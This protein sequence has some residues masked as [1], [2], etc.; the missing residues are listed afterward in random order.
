MK[1][2]FVF[3]ASAV[4][5][6]GVI[7]YLRD[8][9]KGK[10][11]PNIVSWIT[12]TLLTGIA[13]IAELVGHEYHTAIFTAA[14]V[15]ETGSVVVLGLLKGY[16]KYTRFDY[17]CQASAIVGLFLWWLF[18]S[19]AVAVVAAVVI[20]AIGVLP[21]IRHS[22]NQPGEETWISFA[23]AGLGGVFAVLALSTYN[24]TNLPYPLYIALVNPIVIGVIFY[25]LTTNP[26]FKPSE[27]GKFIK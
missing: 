6:V 13:T 10:T 3:L 8:I 4:T 17:V 9:I 14:A 19:P 15:L 23:L 18:N 27:T 12:W 26:N 22:W 24:W 1:N 7:P 11:K 16:V 21:T 5:I 2:L 20:D 25:R